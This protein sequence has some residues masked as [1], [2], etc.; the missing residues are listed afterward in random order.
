MS[1]KIP[2]NRESQQHVPSTKVH[3]CSPTLPTSPVSHLSF[4]NMNQRVCQLQENP[5]KKKKHTFWSKHVYYTSVAAASHFLWKTHTLILFRESTMTIESFDTARS[6]ADRN[7]PRRFFSLGI[8]VKH[9]NGVPWEEDTQT[10][11]KQL[12]ISPK[13]LTW[14][15][16]CAEAHVLWINLNNNTP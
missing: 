12:K 1:Q 3:I 15:S 14:D 11:T 5:K 16:Y 10:I 7:N 6:T 9:H 8:S 4:Q 13:R 2:S